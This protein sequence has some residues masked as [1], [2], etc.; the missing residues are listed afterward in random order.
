MQKRKIYITFFALSLW[1]FLF[2]LPAYATNLEIDAE[3]AI[4]VEA[5]SGKV[6]YAKNEDKH[7]EPASVTKLM[8]M[9]IVMDA[10][11]SGKIKMEEKI[12]ASKYACSMGGSQVWLEEGEVRTLKDLLI[13][14]SV[15]SANDASVAVAEHLSGSAEA[16]VE[17]MNF[18][19]KELGMTN[20]HF[21]NTNGLPVDNH[22]V[23]AKDMA[24]LARYSLN[25]PEILALTSI[26]EFTFRDKP[27]LLILYNTNKLLWWYPGTDGLKT[28]WTPRAKR[29]IVTTTK[30]GDLR[31]IAVILG[32]DKPKGHF[33]EATKL[34][35]YG[36]A[37]YAFKKIYDANTPICN[38]EIAKGTM[39]KLA[40]VPARDVGALHI[41]GKKIQS[42]TK[43]VLT[44][45]PKAPIAKGQ[46]LGE[47]IVTIDNQIAEKVDLLAAQAVPKAN[48]F[49]N[50]KTIFTKCF[51]FGA[52]E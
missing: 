28:G 42:A 8:T 49:Y 35:N 10:I 4:L 36:F 29:S 31:L 11:K 13:A 16:F 41:K 21:S 17:Q 1:L 9:V 6:L 37:N 51:T 23:S 20:T 50:F 19:A 22:Y 34:L 2:I 43:L 30:R 5:S 24:I 33:I 27:K 38:V 18:K 14:I 25:Y 7:W 15:G 12:T 46:K 52:L 45:K 44:V 26:K 39:D 32:S 3:G 40:L 47:I 48:F